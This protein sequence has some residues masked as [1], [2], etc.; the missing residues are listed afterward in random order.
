MYCTS[1]CDEVRTLAQA[2]QQKLRNARASHPVAKL[3]SRAFDGSRGMDQSRK[4]DRL[5]EKKACMRVLA[6]I[7]RTN[8]IVD[9]WCLALL[10]AGM[11]YIVFV[12]DVMPSSDKNNTDGKIE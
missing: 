5:F 9:A 12:F 3:T 2:R 6:S 10:I 8:S 11:A 4:L 1:Y 7:D